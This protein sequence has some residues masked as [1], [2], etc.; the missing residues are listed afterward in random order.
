M[1]NAVKHCST[2]KYRTSGKT[3]PDKCTYTNK[4]GHINK[5]SGRTCDYYQPMDNIKEE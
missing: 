1:D 3:Y 4:E 2:C 5:L